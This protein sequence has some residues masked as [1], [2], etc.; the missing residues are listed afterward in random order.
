MQNEETQCIFPE[1]TT[2][3]IDTIIKYVLYVS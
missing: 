1:N 3:Q 2:I